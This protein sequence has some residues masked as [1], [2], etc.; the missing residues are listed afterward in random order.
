MGDSFTLRR[1]QPDDSDRVWELHEDAMRGVDAL[2]NE[3]VFAEVLPNDEELD[4]DLRAIQETYIE[5]GG[6]F[7]VGEIDKKI[8]AMGAFKPADD[9]VAEIKRMR[10]DPDHQRQ[11]YGQQ[12]LNTLETEAKERGFTE[13]VLDTTARQSGA[14]QLY[15]KNGYHET[16]RETIGEYEMIFYR[17]SDSAHLND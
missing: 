15:E 9:L 16:R 10:V 14:R 17:K 4:E 3:S 2:A 13:F 6:A 5:P 7:F 8:V 11:G 1:Y 12:V